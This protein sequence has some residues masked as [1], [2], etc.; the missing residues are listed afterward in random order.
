MMK[1]FGLIALLFGLISSSLAQTSDSHSVV[2]NGRVSELSLLDSSEKF[3]SGATIE[4]WSSD[5]LLDSITTNQKGRYECRLPYFGSYL[6]KYK[7][8][9]FV[10][11]MVEIDAT[12]FA[13]ETRVRGFTLEVDMTL[14]KKQPGCR[15]F[16]FLGEVPI[17]KASFNKRENTVVW[18]GE[19]TEAINSRIRLAAASCSK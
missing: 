6:I 13:R 15:E 7:S 4:I 17:G 3:M 10:M 19:H 14:F 2:L 1:Y 5:E 16:E 9:G 12:D 8:E 18:D 11:K